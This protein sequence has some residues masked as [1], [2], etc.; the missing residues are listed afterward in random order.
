MHAPLE[1]QND[2]RC[3][4][5]D[6]FKHRRNHERSIAER[7]RR[8]NE[9]H[10]LPCQSRTH[11]SVEESR[12]RDGWRIIP[13]NQINIKYSGVRTSTPQI[14]AIQNTILANLMSAPRT[15]IECAGNSIAAP[16]LKPIRSIW[17]Q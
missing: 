12:M 15:T 14:A 6:F 4:V 13:A 11:E 1:N 7:V 9:K 16:I 5:T 10:D 17:L 8:D 2:H 3:D